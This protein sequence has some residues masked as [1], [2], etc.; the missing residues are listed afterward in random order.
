MQLPEIDFSNLDFKEMGA[1]PL[2]MQVAVNVLVVILIIIL[3]S[4]FIFSAEIDT[5]NA[6]LTKLDVA[7]KNFKEKY[8]T[9]VNFDAYKDQMKQMQNTFNEFV[10]ELPPSSNIPALIDSISKIGEENNLKFAFIKIG[11]AKPGSGFYMEL[12]I[13]LGITGTYHNLGS[14]VSDISKLPRIVTFGNFDIKRVLPEQDPN[15]LGLLAINISIKTYWLSSISD[16]QKQS[17]P[18]VGNKNIPNKT[19]LNPANM[20]TP[21]RNTDPNNKPRPTQKYTMP[22]QPSNSEK[23]N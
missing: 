9:V 19:M 23:V 11:E 1:W 16:E 14:F 5:L 13:T 2:V 8:G 17:K 18:A 4:V 10:Q 21:D 12:P 3:A 7:Q 22:N 6:S 20:S 15:N